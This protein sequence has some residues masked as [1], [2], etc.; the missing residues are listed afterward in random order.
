MNVAYN[1]DC[2][3]AM[4]KMPDHCF[5]LP[6]WILHTDGGNTAGKAEGKP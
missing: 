4:R 2:L 3:E 1:M 5:D 6:W